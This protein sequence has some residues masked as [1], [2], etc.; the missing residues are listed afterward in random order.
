MAEIPPGSSAVQ[1]P[2]LTPDAPRSSWREK[3]KH[4][5]YRHCRGLVRGDG[6]RACTCAR[7]KIRHL[8]EKEVFSPRFG[9]NQSRQR[10]A[11]GFGKKGPV[12]ENRQAT[13]TIPIRLRNVYNHRT[14]AVGPTLLDV[15]AQQQQIVSWCV[16]NSAQPEIDT[17]FR[18]GKL[19]DAA[20]PHVTA[21]PKR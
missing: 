3:P 21:G 11:R 4:C 15:K 14:D 20:A 5:V 6:R 16:S 10:S 1:N 12:H 17:R 18:R 13:R 7:R 9:W 2:P 19:K 8:G